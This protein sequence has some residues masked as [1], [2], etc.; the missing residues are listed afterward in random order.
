MSFN[1]KYLPIKEDL[2]TILLENGS[3][4][5]YI[6]YV[7]TVDAYIGSTESIEFIDT[8]VDI[9]RSADAEFYSIG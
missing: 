9:W 4:R 2:I 3:N 5:F 8:F 6:W 1:K 7:K